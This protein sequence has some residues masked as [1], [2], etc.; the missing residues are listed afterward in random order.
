MYTEEEAKWLWCP[1]ARVGSPEGFAHN[2]NGACIASKCAMWR[3]ENLA[4]HT[5]NTDMLGY[6]GLG[7]KP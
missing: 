5:P 3:W 2:E 4:G 7:G 1:M 6:C